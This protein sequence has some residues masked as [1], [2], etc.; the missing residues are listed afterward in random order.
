VSER[1]LHRS[2]D[3][4]AEVS[5][6]AEGGSVWL[7]Q[8]EIAELFATTKQNI[9]RHVRNPRGRS[10]GRALNGLLSVHSV[11]VNREPRMPK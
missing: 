6:R 5:L 7:T 3:G 10:G 11:F 2:D 1:I 8:G 4:H 9:R